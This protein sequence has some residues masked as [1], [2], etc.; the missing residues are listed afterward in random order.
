MT[1]KSQPTPLLDRISTPADL[2]HLDF[3]EL[4][5]LAKE[6]RQEVVE[7][8]AHNGGFLGAS[9]GVVELTIALHYVFNTPEDLIVWDVG[10]QTC[11]HKILTE[12][13][14]KMRFL[15][16]HGGPSYYPRRSESTYDPLDST[17]GGTA[18][19]SALGLAV[20]RDLAGQSHQVVSVV[21]DNSICGG[22]AFEAFNNAGIM[23]HKLLV[24]LNDQY[25]T[26]TD[27][28]GAM[29]AYLKRILSKGPYKSLRQLMKDSAGR[30]SDVVSKI[31]DQKVG[32][33]NHETV[34]EQFGFFYIGPIDGHNL[35]HLIKVL[36]S[37]R[38]RIESGPVLLHIAT[39]N[40]HGYAPAVAAQNNFSTVRRFDPQTGIQELPDAQTYQKIF[41]ETLT[42]EARND[43]KIVVITT[44]LPRGRELNIFARRYPDR[45]FDMAIAEQHAVSFAASLASQGMKPF[46][47]LGAPFLQKALDQITNDVVFQNLPVRF[48]VNRAGFVGAEGMSYSGI[49]D[50]AFLCNLPNMVVM[51]PADATDLYHM[52]A[53]AIQ[54]QDCPC[55]IRY[56]SHSARGH[57][58]LGASPVPLQLGKGRIVQQGTSV[59]LLSLGTR[60]SECFLAASLLQ[61]HDL[62]VTIADARFAKPLD[63]TLILKLAKDHEVLVTIEDG[64]IGGFS[65]Q[66]LMLLAN[67]NRLDK[68]LKFRPLVVPDRM[69][70]QAPTE[71]QYEMAGLKAQN[72]VDTVLE[73]VGKQK[74]Q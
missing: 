62:K 10:H 59:A 71:L 33:G 52:T 64:A 48:A 28:M 39:Q 27:G 46:I 72:I 26:A 43:E 11:P 31:P 35:E 74:Q 15:G 8:A 57:V 7:V 56:P 19:S 2:R 18:V 53:T 73:A 37:I 58:A 9:L 69:I 13:R 36:K 23:P 3:K 20:A 49:Y 67:K 51:S 63:E 6:V 40:G 5:Q 32:P 22:I 60:L 1:F 61:N 65:A 45:F 44:D 24:I 29:G 55:V 66:V 25:Q 47:L 50:I 12:R 4:E 70:E 68:G 21:G 16:R 41:V 42:T 34:F 17:H 14:R 54:L 30:F 38:K